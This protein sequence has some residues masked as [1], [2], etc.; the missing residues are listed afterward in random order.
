MKICKWCNKEFH[1]PPCREKTASTCSKK[2]SQLY[3]HSL[4]H[5]EK[6]VCKCE[7]CGKEFK[8]YPS[9]IYGKHQYCSK[10]CQDKG[11]TTHLYECEV[12]KNTFHRPVRKNQIVRF[13]SR[14]C[15]LVTFHEERNPVNS[16]CAVCNKPFHKSPSALTSGEG[17]YCSWQCKRI[18]S[19]GVNTSGLPA[20]YPHYYSRPDWRKRRYECLERDNFTCTRC[21]NDSRQLHAHH[22]KRRTE[23]G[24][25]DLSNLITL[26]RVCH[27]IV[28]SE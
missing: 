12:C 28:E 18:G 7:N 21:G 23:G 5:F 8:R 26:C 11:R 15:M 25:D 14:K 13:C 17:V 19:T 2:C 1:V 6:T 3:R 9:K 22:I 4:I 10:Q 16:Y 24:S 27:R 20:K